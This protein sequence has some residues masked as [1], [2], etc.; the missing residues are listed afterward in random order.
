MSPFAALETRV[1]ASVLQHLANARVSIDG[2]EPVP[3]IFKDPS[4]TAAVG[5]GVDDTSPTVSVSSTS[6]P[7]DPEGLPVT[8]NDEAFA[9]VRALPDGSGLTLLLLELAI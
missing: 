9:I 3:G 1:N 7:P 6:V 5:V 8:I 4:R 2:G